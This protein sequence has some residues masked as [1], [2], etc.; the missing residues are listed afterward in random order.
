MA[1]M[2]GL[3]ME[4][5]KG[6]IFEHE[7]KMARQLALMVM[8]KPEPPFWASFIP[9]IFV[10]YAQKLKQY[11]QGLDD[12]VDNY[13]VSR[14]HAMEAALAAMVEDSRVDA[15]Q[16]L[17]KAGDMPPAAKLLYLE[18]VTLLIDHYQVLLDADGDCH[19]DLA[20]DGYK[21]KRGYI[22]AW[23]SLNDAER[24]FNMALLPDVDGDSED[25]LNVIQKMNA[26][27]VHLRYQD[28]EAVFPHETN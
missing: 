9:M 1:N 16:L 28:A 10:F 21:N 23:T 19:E 11:S 3:S 14:R 13:L 8:D 27:I 5:K 18:W 20:R 22:S 17:K 6:H 15:R 26:G 2:A 7:K 25:I 4:E 12:F 24:A